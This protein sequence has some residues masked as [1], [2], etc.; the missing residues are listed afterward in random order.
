MKLEDFP[1]VNHFGLRRKMWYDTKDYAY[2][3][4][5]RKTFR[6][7]RALGDSSEHLVIG[8]QNGDDWYVSDMPNKF[9]KGID[10][11]EIYKIGETK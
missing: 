7:Y 4:F 11:S 3:D 6:Y 5:E 10:L 1:K 2:Y 8:N 9:P